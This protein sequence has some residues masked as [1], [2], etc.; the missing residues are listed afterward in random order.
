MI[1]LENLHNRS[2][3]DILDEYL[4]KIPYLSTEWTDYQE[5]DPGIT[6]VELFSWLKWVQHEYLNRNF[7]GVSTKFLR[8]LDVNRYK[9]K[10]AKTFLEVSHVKENTDLPVRTKWKSGDMVFENTENQTLINSSILNIEFDNPE[11]PSQEEYYKFDGNNVFY[12]FGKNTERKDKNGVKRRFIISFDAP[13]SQGKMFNIFFSVYNSHDLKRNP[14]KEDSKFVPMARIKWEYY[15]VKNGKK[16]WHEVSVV[17]DF[18]YQ[19]LFSGIVGMKIDGT[20]EPM[21][22]EYK[23][24]ATL[25]YDEYDYPPRI[26]NVIPNVFSVVQNESRCENIV[27]KK[28]DVLPDFTVDVPRNLA[29]YGR[30]EVYLKSH[31]GWVRTFSPTFKSFTKKGKL[32][33][34]L[35]EVWSEIKN[36]KPSDE[37]VMIVSC[38]QD[39]KDNMVLGSGTGMTGQTVKFE[40]KNVLYNDLELLI[41]EKIDGKEVFFKWKRVDDFYSSGKYDRHFVYD[42]DE[43]VITFGDH[44]H[45]MAP[46]PGND[47]IRICGL[48]FTSGYKSNIKDKMISSVI[49]LNNALNNSRVFQITEATGGRDIESIEHA[50]ARAAEIFSNPYRA[51]SKKDYENI[52][53]STPGLMFTNVK[54]LPNYMPGEDV[55]NQNCVTIAVR[56]NRKVGLTLPKSF[57]ENIMNHINKYR[58]INT[59]V[60]VI[61]PEYIGL[62]ITGKIVVDSF[63][64]EED[65]TIE[66]EIKRFVKNMNNDLG[67]TLHFGD[68]FGMIDKLKYVSRLDSLRIVPIGNFVQKNVSEDIIIPPNGVYYVEKIDFNYVKNSEIY[69]G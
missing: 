41:S 46:R 23:I 9:N 6:M 56:W 13:I 39:F 50:S 63:Y 4:N 35:S 43:K 52:V 36:L 28:E 57:E 64:R 3:D 5:A 32:S 68:I 33:V 2:L 22:G 53:K 34:D 16:G 1:E 27:I 59:H 51:V 11:M 69:K 42:E 60:K 14:I 38:D 20:T 65:R 24:R 40:F 17:N 26:D 12:V 44:E 61:S 45:G 21:D 58:L 31:G 8:L 55:S 19:F 25:L 7:P 37:A 15:G 30:S 62:I 47:N 29:L 18:T 49:S 54:I 67:K 48:R 66:K 10:G